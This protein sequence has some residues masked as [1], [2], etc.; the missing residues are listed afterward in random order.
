M[1]NEIKKGKGEGTSSPKLDN[2]V[3]EPFRFI[4]PDKEDKGKGEKPPPTPPSSPSS[5]SSSSSHKTSS[6]KKK[7]KKTD[8]T[9]HASSEP[10]ADT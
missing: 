2:G 1:Y 5:S 3:E 9:L 6:S 8:R 4:P 7:K 10:V